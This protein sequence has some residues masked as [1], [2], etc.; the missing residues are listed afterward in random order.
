MKLHAI[1]N[2][3]QLNE[4]RILRITMNQVADYA[5]RHHYAYLYPEAEN[6]GSDNKSSAATIAPAGYGAVLSIASNQWLGETKSAVVMEIENLAYLSE[7]DVIAVYPNGFVRTLYRRDSKHNFILMTAQC[8]SFCL[9]CSQPPQQNNDFDRI[10]EHLQLIELIDPA[11]EQL[12]ITGGEPTLFKD[13]FLR[14]IQHCQERL[15]FTRLHVLTNGRM[16][17]YRRFAEALSAVDHPNLMLGIPLYS[18]VDSEH[19]YIVQAKG[20]FNE[21]VMGLH[22]LARYNVPV[23]IRVVLHRQTI[24]RL[25]KLG[26]FIA[27]NLPFAG[28]VALMGLEMFGFVHRNYDEVWIDPHD[29]Q[30]ELKEAV[31]ILVAGGLS[32]S[33]YNHQ[34]CLLNPELWQFAR[35]SISDWKNIYLPECERCSVKNSCGGFFQSAAKKH[36]A[37]INAI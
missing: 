9:M 6:G 16:F 3:S 11:T 29:Y 7:G 33:I 31:E 4:K 8:N 25:R 27:R 30:A 5:D 23:E 15:P 34:L 35:Q 19:D 32:V 13:D 26:E 2:V 14:V 12:G 28:H 21:T 1:G 20:A 17:F 10:A 22:H 36:S 18:D 37:Y 24:P